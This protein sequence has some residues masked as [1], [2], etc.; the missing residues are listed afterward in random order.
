M[1]W[2][3]FLVG[4]TIEFI[5]SNRTS[6]TAHDRGY[7]QGCPGPF[8]RLR[9]FSFFQ[10]FSSTL[11]WRYSFR[12]A[13]PLVLGLFETKHTRIFDTRKADMYKPYQNMLNTMRPKLYDARKKVITAV[14]TWTRASYQAWCIGLTNWCEIPVTQKYE[15]QR[16]EYL[17]ICENARILHGKLAPH[18]RVLRGNKPRGEL[19]RVRVAK[20]ASHPDKRC[21]RVRQSWDRHIQVIENTFLPVTN[22]IREAAELV[23]HGAKCK[24]YDLDT[25]RDLKKKL[26]RWKQMDEDEDCMADEEGKEYWDILLPRICS[27]QT[28]RAV[29]RQEPSHMKNVLK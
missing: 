25:Q 5:F 14:T 20:A 24:T 3:H 13:L 2:L 18:L 17:V 22:L 11:L 28:F 12:P 15:H 6:L 26:K 8:L 19:P 9:K 29:S 21:K 7:E 1:C 10:S 16:I 27:S 23:C 4:L